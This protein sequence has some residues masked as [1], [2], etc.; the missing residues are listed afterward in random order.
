MI[1]FKASDIVYINSLRN[2]YFD[3][4][5]DVQEYYIE[6]QVNKAA[7]YNIVLDETGIGYFILGIDNTLLEYYLLNT[8]NSHYNDVFNEIL[9][10]FNVNSILCK[11]FDKLLNTVCRN[12]N[13][14]IQNEGLLFRK[15]EGTKKEDSS[16]TVRNAVEKE[17]DVLD[18]MSEGLFEN[19]LEIERYILSDQLKIFR[20]HDI[21]A[22]VGIITK[23]L[24]DKPFYDIGMAVRKE[25]RNRGIGSYIIN[26]LYH[27]L[28]ELG[29]KPIVSCNAD[30][31]SSVKAIQKAGFIKT[32]E[33]IRY[34]NRKS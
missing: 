32:D 15:F 17:I 10:Q 2:K 4:L 23:I 3:E 30:N 22:G 13:M 14:D 19:R 8:F 33:I 26:Y 12:N 21:T 1:K 29:Y 24:P 16:I 20:L 27:Y 18:E 9:L 7:V 28:H 25:Y 31:I 5:P 11:S 6:Q 34:I